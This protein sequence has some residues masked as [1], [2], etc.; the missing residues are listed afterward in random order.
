MRYRPDISGLRACAVVP[1]VLYHLNASLVPG[2]YV[3][4]DV[5]FVISGYLITALILADLGARRFS[6]VT[7]YDR[8]IRRIVPAY[9]LMALATALAALVILPPAQL[10]AFGESLKAASIFFA[11]RYFLSATGYF[12]AG[13]EQL[14]LH[15]WSLSIE[16]Q[17]YL[18]WPLLLVVVSHPRLVRFRGLLVWALLLL[19][20]FAATRNAIRLPERA[21]YNAGGRFWELLMGAVLA[22]NL[23]PHLRRQAVAEGIAALGLAMILAAL[24]LFNHDTLFPGATALL[25]TGGA[26]LVLW[27]G[28][29]GRTTYVGRLLA[30]T[31]LVGIGLISYSLYLWHWPVL[32]VYRYVTQATPGLTAGMVLL[33]LMLAL[34]V[35]S[36]R[37]RVCC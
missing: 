13:A 14:L 28:E 5:F 17:F 20:L 29:G 16:E 1:V 35:L 24:A 25:P 26:L 37:C 11:N 33:A 15:T 10:V 34:S 2:G 32:A 6:L 22:L 4:V 3:G 19:S 27:A 12:D 7:F 23:L 18:A 36:W 9:A 8:R 21:F 30:W 31:P